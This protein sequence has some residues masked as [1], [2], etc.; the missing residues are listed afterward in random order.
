MR[1]AW[2]GAG[3]GRRLMAAALADAWQRHFERIELWVRG[4]NAAAIALYRKM[5]F[6]EEGRRRDAI[7]LGFGSEDEVLMAMHAPAAAA[8]ADGKAAMAARRETT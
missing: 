1:G 7:R 5:G 4:P 6:V 2:R 3:L 8:G